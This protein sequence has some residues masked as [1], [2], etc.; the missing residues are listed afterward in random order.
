LLIFIP[1]FKLHYTNN[2]V[3]SAKQ[4]QKSPKGGE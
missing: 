2:A 4:Y 3:Y 1:I